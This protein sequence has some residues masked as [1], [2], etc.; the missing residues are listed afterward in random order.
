MPREIYCP[1][2]GLRYVDSFLVNPSTRGCENLIK[3]QF[4]EDE[5]MVLLQSWEHIVVLKRRMVQ[6]AQSRRS[7]P[8]GRA[9]AGCFEEFACV[10][11]S[12]VAAFCHCWRSYMPAMYGH[13]QRF[14]YFISNLIRNPIKSSTVGEIYHLRQLQQ[15]VRGATP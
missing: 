8:L 3:W 11:A 15:A 4:C 1:S 2:I 13:I 14:S 6:K 7:E 5:W 9:H 10:L 12:S